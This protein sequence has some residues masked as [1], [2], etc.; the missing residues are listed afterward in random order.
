MCTV[1]SLLCAYVRAGT[2]E[3][4]S[5]QSFDSQEAKQASHIQAHAVQRKHKRARVAKRSGRADAKAD[6]LKLTIAI[7]QERTGEYNR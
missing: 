2:R 4:V 6:I 3:L 5:K 1:L 7:R